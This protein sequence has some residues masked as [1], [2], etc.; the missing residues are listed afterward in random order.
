MNVSCLAVVSILVVVFA[1][2]VVV[3]G[4]AHQGPESVDDDV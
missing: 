4:I 2:F 3:W 1:V